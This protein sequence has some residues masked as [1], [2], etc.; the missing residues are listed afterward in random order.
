VVKGLTPPFSSR[1]GYFQI[2]F[3][4]ILPDKFG[5]RTGAET[6][7]ERRVFGAGLTRDNTS[8]CLTP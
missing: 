7:I 5:Q 3:I 4:F 8:Y 2:F 1:N 6:G